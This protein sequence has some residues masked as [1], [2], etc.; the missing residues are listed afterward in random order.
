M[1]QRSVPV[2]ELQQLLLS[3]QYLVIALV[4]KARL[5]QGL[6]H[7]PGNLSPSDTDGYKGELAPPLPFLFI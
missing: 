5:E 6:G 4:D 7:P 1:Q 2:R 3:G